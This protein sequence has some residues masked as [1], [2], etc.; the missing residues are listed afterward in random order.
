MLYGTTRQF[1]EAFGLAN[2]KDLPA[3]ADFATLNRA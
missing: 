2:L 1:L 3:P